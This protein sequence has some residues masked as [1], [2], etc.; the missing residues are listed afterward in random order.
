[1][2]KAETLLRQAE[3]QIEA[4]W[5]EVDAQWAGMVA[6]A[7]AEARRV[8]ADA[9]RDAS[10][11][12]TAARQEAEAMLDAARLD[13]EAVHAL[14]AAEAVVARGVPPEDLEGLREAIDRL[15]AELSR[16]VDA[17]FDA[18]PAVEAT[19]AA[20]DQLLGDEGG[21]EAEPEAE[22]VAVGPA[23]KRRRLRRLFR[24]G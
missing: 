16:V 6:A 3:E 19:A 20:V 2:D 10:S 5:C 22:L 15:R 17:A 14:A 7:E 11:L 23:P 8:I 24:R 18:L 9:Q 21:D 1:M 12:L 4:W 13:V